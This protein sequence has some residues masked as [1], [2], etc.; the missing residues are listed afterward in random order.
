MAKGKLIVIEG[1][2]GSGKATQTQILLE[3]LINDG[4]IV[5]KISFPDYDKSSSV[6]V[7]MYL[8]GDF[9]KDA[10]TVNPYV[11]STFYAVDRV[12]S[13][14]TTWQKD[15]LNGNIILADRYTTSNAIY[16]LSKVNSG[17]EDAFINWLEDFEYN[18]LNIPKPDVV[19]YLDVEPKISQKL[20]IDRYNGDNSK[21]DI[22]E[23]NL[24]FLLNC[25]KTA[26]CVAD[27]L[28]W[29]VIKC[30]DGQNIRPL[31]DIANDIYDALKNL[32]II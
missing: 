6:L 27:K 19:I 2:D 12:A 9:G 14:L 24:N 8:G 29:Q 18:K 25:R 7:K 28:D 16:Q 5:N 3:R 11:A 30:D 15:Y 17:E 10:D 4:K 21:K 23:S 1:L 22:H 26:L 32:H 31:N 20:I 13:Y